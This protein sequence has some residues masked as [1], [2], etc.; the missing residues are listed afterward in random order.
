M[1]WFSSLRQQ[2]ANF[3]A[4]VSSEVKKASEELLADSPA[5]DVDVGLDAV[6]MPW[7]KVNLPAELLPFEDRIREVILNLSRDIDTFTQGVDD[8]ADGSDHVGA[9]TREDTGAP[10][11]P[12]LSQE[13]F[14]RETFDFSG[15]RVKV[16]KVLMTMDPLLKQRRYEIVRPK[17][18]VARRHCTERGFWANYFFHVSSV[19]RE[20]AAG[21]VDARGDTEQQEQVFR[22]VLA[23]LESCSA[24]PM[25]TT[26]TTAT[27]LPGGG[28]GGGEASTGGNSSSSSSS[29]SSSNSNSSSSSSDARDGSSPSST[30]EL[31]DGSSTTRNPA[32]AG[33]GV[34]GGGGGSGGSVPPLPAGSINAS[35]SSSSAS[36]STGATA[37]TADDDAFL[38]MD[39]A[40]AEAA[41][42]RA[43]AF[44]D[45][46]DDDDYAG[47]AN[48]YDDDDDD[49]DDDGDGG[50]A[51]DDNDDFRFVRVGC[52][53]SFGIVAA[54]A[55]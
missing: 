44:D 28:G 31:A 15:E 45:D 50:A 39:L 11:P 51:D 48:E 29:S 36:S 7:Q 18:S 5:P 46:D 55:A 38:S 43:N 34:A 14:R 32:L 20:L 8:A 35:S 9:P 40:A 13:E 10:S 49:D 47:M 26:A 16:A 33:A 2:A 25:A 21:V 27:P 23:R 53:R 6:A 3:A 37:T 52:G 4:A 17:R 42:Q 12:A 1:S 19:I 54:T 30:N 24:A 41:M 22:T